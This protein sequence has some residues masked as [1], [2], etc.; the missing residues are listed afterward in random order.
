MSQFFLDEILEYWWIY[1][2]YL[3]YGHFKP[4]VALK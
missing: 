1:D 2:R 3:K 4:L